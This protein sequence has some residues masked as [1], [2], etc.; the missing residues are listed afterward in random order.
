MDKSLVYNPAHYNHAG[1]KECWEEMREIFGDEA[2]AIFDILSAYKYLYRAGSK[3]GNSADQDKAKISNYVVHCKTLL[4]EHPVEDVMDAEI[5][6][7]KF[8]KIYNN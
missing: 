2:V 6:L 5:V 7:A 1:R 4:N 8:E 3:E